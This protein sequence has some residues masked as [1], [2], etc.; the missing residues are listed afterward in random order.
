MANLFSWQLKEETQK[1]SD[2]LSYN[3]SSKRELSIFTPPHELSLLSDLFKT[4]N[5][6]HQASWEG[7]QQPSRA[8]FPY[9]QGH[10]PNWGC[11][12]LSQTLSQHV[13][14]IFLALIFYILKSH[15]KSCHLSSRNPIVPFCLKRNSLF[16]LQFML[17]VVLSWVPQ[18]LPG[19]PVLCVF[20]HGIPAFSS[21]IWQNWNVSIG[22]R[23]STKRTKCSEHL[24]DGRHLDSQ[25]FKKKMCLE[26]YWS[27]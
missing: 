3:N 15:D 8:F 11:F 4:P 21:W 12:S 9:F 25:N 23:A 1:G 19:I 22:T 13:Q 27:A 16:G 6:K 5:P 18:T 2:K 24:S 14:A 20:G 26:M 17:S 10:I 7:P